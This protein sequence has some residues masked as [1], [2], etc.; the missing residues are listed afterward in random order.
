LVYAYKDIPIDE[1][2]NLRAQYNNFSSVADREFL[3]KELTLVAGFG[4]N[5]D[6]RDGVKNAVSNMRAAGINTRMVSGD[7]I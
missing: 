1:W 3:E 2:G 6:L 4:L 7:N 5:D